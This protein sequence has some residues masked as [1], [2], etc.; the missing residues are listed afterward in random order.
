MIAIGPEI[1]C[2]SVS[3]FK[4]FCYSLNKRTEGNFIRKC[5]GDLV[6]IWCEEG[7]FKA[8]L[9]RKSK[10]KKLWP[11]FVG[12]QNQVWRPIM[13]QLTNHKEM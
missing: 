6:S 9:F 7:N 8:L 1:S 10:S 3:S 12:M 2:Q 13:V 5:T 11:S 4:T